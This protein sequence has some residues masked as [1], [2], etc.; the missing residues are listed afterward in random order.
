MV[1]RTCREARRKG[2]VWVVGVGEMRHCLDWNGLGSRR[3]W[4]VGPCF[5]K[6]GG[7]G[8]LVARWWVV[9]L[10]GTGLGWVSQAFCPRI[11]GACD[12]ARPLG[13][14]HQKSLSFTCNLSKCLLPQ[15]NENDKAH[16][17]SSRRH[18]NEQAC[19]S[20]SEAS[21]SWTAPAV[22]QCSLRRPQLRCK[23]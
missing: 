21:R 5:W 15:V 10:L 19:W 18:C 2:E 12:C 14:V 9:G 4:E 8:G 3:L 23:T 6:L 1:G 16:C 20:S 13:E 22:C 7:V 11:S 17:R